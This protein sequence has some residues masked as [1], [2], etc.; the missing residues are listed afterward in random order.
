MISA[1]NQV[2]AER[3]EGRGVA[4]S[5]GNRV[6]LFVWNRAAPEAD[7]SSNDVPST[8]ENPLG[9]NFI[10]EPATLSRRV[11]GTNEVGSPGN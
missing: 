1:F 11:A 8:G 9:E 7:H 2:M 10:A 5:A 4:G 3:D 6:G